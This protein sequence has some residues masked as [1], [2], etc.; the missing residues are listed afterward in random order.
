MKL[1]RKLVGLF[2]VIGLV[3]W[4]FPAN[5]VSTV[6]AGTISSIGVALSSSTKS[7]TS[8]YTITF[9][10]ATTVANFAAINVSFQ[11]PPDAQFGVGSSTL[12][13]ESSSTFT[14]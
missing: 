8:N 10:P 4:Q 1:F 7:A 3:I 13:S 6:R 9:T 11:G 14:D 2:A 5:S 12:G